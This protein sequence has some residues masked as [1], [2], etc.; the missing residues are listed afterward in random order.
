MKEGMV[1]Q[2]TAALAIIP[3]R[4][5][6][7]GVPRKNVRM[8]AGKPLIA[9]TIQNARAARTVA[10]VVVSTDDPEI[11]DVATHYGAEVI[12]RPKELSGDRA[13]S[14]S[15]LLHA[16]DFLSGGEGYDPE[17]CVF[18][19]CTSPLTLPEDIDG[20][21]NTLLEEGADSALSVAPFHY[22]LWQR[23]E[24]GEAV[25]VH[26]DKCVRLPRQEREPQFLETGAVYAMKTRGFRAAR[27]RFFGKTAFY[28]MPAARCLEIDEPVDFLL[29][30]GLMK[31]GRR[32]KVRASLPQPV[33]ALILDFDG[34]LTDNRVIVF[35]DGREAVMCDRGDGWGLAGLK[36][37]RIPVLVL[38]AETNPVVRARCDKLGLECLYG[39]QNKLPALTDWLERGGIDAARAVYVGNDINDL[40]CLQAVGCGVAVAD[41][42]PYV[43]AA[44]Q[45]VLTAS[46]GRGA[47]REI[48]D[49]ILEQEEAQTN[50]A[51][52]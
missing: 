4:G 51:Q 18:L 5:G 34:V 43:K 10:R 26:H 17:I 21:V 3:A 45:I 27:H 22:F 1:H 32:E 11:G 30:E 48:G 14:E 33:S 50:A 23:G 24:D 39:V 42:H 49:L 29:A 31:E 20:V 15:A 13:S 2:E 6:S 35:Q 9:Y 37:R 41:A 28:V 19:Q 40:A 44:A 8:L 7:R 25:P 12:W 38:T 36:R 47:V 16:L 46:G 52:G